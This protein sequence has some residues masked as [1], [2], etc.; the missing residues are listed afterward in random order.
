MIDLYYANLIKLELQFLELPSLHSSQLTWAIGKSLQNI[1]KVEIKGPTYSL[2]TGCRKQ[3]TVAFH[4]HCHFSAD[5]HSQQEFIPG[6]STPFAPAGSSDSVSLTSGT[7]AC[8]ALRQRAPVSLVK[9][10]HPRSW[11]LEGRER[12]TRVP[13][14]SL[15]FLAQLHRLKLFL[16]FP[17]S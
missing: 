15:W 7:S 3:G 6:P 4:T 2:R 11:K 16:A 1:W 9:W 13:S 17:T 8:S 14:P 12:L 5:L 10:L